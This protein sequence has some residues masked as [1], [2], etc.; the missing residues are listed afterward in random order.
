MTMIEDFFRKRLDQ[1]IDL[2]HPLAVLSNRM[3]W[4]KIGASL[5]HRFTR[6]VRSGKK[7]EGIDMYEHTQAMA[8]AGASNAG[9]P[10]LTTRLMVSQPS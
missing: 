4:Q 5:I 2:L 8:K 3:P 9:R 7:I 10:R 1:L 6:Q